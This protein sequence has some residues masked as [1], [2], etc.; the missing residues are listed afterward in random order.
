MFVEGARHSGLNAIYGR[1]EVVQVGT[2]L[3]QTD[4]VV[5]GPAANVTD[6]VF[7]FTAGA[8]RDVLNVRGWEGG[9]GAESRSTGHET[10]CDPLTATT[11]SR[12]MCLSVCGRLPVHWAA[13]GTCACRNRW[14]VTPKCR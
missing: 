5:E 9:V 7:A 4:A 10:H 13:C 11:R 3:L 8:V 1:F 14:S 12:S 6:P 2:A